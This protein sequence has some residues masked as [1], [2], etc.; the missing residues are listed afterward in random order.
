MSHRPD[1]CLLVR[2]ATLYCAIKANFII[3]KN[4]L[5]MVHPA[6]PPLAGTLLCHVEHIQKRPCR[7]GC[8]QPVQVSM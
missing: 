4:R 6:A 2:T 5:A 8:R 7:D 1:L 3:L